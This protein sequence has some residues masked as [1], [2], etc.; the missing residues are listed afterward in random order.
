LTFVNPTEEE[1]EE[2]DGLT[3][4]LLPELEKRFS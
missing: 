1:E 4:H 3:K 2:D